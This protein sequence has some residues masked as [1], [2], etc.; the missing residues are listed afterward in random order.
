MTGQGTTTAAG[1]LKGDSIT[2]SRDSSRGSHGRASG[3][4][5]TRLAFVRLMLV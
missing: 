5:G 4:D 2:G 3:V 1:A